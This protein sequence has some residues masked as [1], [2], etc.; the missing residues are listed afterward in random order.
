MKTVK[1]KTVKGKIKGVRKQRTLHSLQ[2]SYAFKRVKIAY[3]N[4]TLRTR[5]F[6]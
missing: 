1:G 4:R 6:V 2:D 5:D 3:K